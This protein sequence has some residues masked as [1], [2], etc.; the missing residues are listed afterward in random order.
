MLLAIESKSEHPLADAVVAKLKNEG[1]NPES[2]QNFESITGMGAEARSID[3][4]RYYIGNQRLLESKNI[5]LSSSVQ[6]QSSNWSNEGKTVIF[7]ANESSVLAILAISD[8]IKE[9]SAYAIKTLQERGID[10][11]MLTGDNKQTAKAVAEQVG[12]DHFK[13]EVMPSDKADFVKELQARGKV[14]AMVL[15]LIHI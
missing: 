4:E 14:V 13:A 1:L 8:E 15:S 11:Y 10:V 5:L 7:F 3:G 12:I 2:I 9:S 6:S